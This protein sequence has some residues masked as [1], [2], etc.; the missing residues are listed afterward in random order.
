VIEA[1][2][3]K[4]DLGVMYPA[5]VALSLAS[6]R[7]SGNDAG[8]DATYDCPDNNNDAVDVM[9]GDIGVSMTRGKRDLIDKRQSTAIT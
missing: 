6:F 9:G 5:V 1:R 8:T 3:N 7:S 4:S 2:I